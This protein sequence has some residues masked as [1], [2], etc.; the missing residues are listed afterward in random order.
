MAPSS[1]GAHRADEAGGGRDRHETHHDAGGA[2][3]GGGAAGPEVVEQ[4]PDHERGHR[5]QEGVG[6][7]ERG[8][9]VRGQR[10][11]AVEPEPAEPEEAGAEQH[12]GHV[13]RQDGLAAVVLAGP[14]HERRHERGDAGVDVHDGAA[15]EV[16]HAPGH[17][18]AAAPDPVRHRGVD[19]ERPEHDEREVRPEPHALHDRARDQRRGD[20]REGALVGHEQDVRDGALGLEA[21]AGQ[22]RIRGPADPG[23]PSA[24]ARLYASSAQTTP[25]APSAAKLIIMVFSEFLERTSPP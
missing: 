11:A 20:D 7:G 8:E 10:A 6:E 3:H 12:E 1:Q 17:E 24:N 14:E 16:E 25:T 22:Q 9:L 4:H 13:V 19:E 2:A 5:G 18:P 21:H 23:I 15:G